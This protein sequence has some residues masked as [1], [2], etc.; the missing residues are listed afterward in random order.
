MARG[1]TATAIDGNILN[2]YKS[3]VFDANCSEDNHAV[4]LVGYG[5][6][7]LGTE[8][9]KIRNSWGTDWGESGYIR[10]ARNESNNKSCFITNESFTI[11]LRK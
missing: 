1:A 9:F 2:Y 6:S 10:I 8:Y 7:E 11:T 3:G 5:I 4:I